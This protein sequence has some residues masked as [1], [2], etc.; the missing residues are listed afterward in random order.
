MMELELLYICAN[1]L[2]QS[3]FSTFNSD[4]SLTCCD[5]PSER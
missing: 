3:I 1:F 4:A 5:S 2:Y